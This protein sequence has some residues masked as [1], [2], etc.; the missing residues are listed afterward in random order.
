MVTDAR[1]LER[2]ARFCRRGVSVV[3]VAHFVGALGQSYVQ[4]R[5]WHCS[6]GSEHHGSE[7]TD[8]LR[9]QIIIGQVILVGRY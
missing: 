8:G 2:R 1:P 7:S 4:G 5:L 6:F 3:G 9:F